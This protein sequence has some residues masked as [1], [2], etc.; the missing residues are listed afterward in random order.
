[1]TLL[2]RRLV[3]ARQVAIG[4][5]H[6]KGG[7]NLRPESAGG[8]HPEG[9]CHL[10]GRDLRRSK[11]QAGDWTEPALQSQPPR[12]L[13]YARRANLHAEPC[14][15]HVERPLQRFPK[16]HGAAKPSVVINRLPESPRRFHR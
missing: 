2:S 12:R 14:E 7:V 9:A 13:Y 6:P 15:R 11:G 3:S 1:M 16:R 4:I 8:E 10:E 5:E